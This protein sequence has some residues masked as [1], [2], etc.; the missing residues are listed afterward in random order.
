MKENYSIDIDEFKQT[1]NNL[2]GTHPEAEWMRLRL[3]E[4]VVDRQI[5]PS[6]SP[7]RP[8]PINIGEKL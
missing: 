2:I 7:E 1:V 8:E 5:K 6:P 4:Y 3:I